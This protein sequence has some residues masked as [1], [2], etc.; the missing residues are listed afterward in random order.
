MSASVDCNLKGVTTTASHCGTQ[1]RPRDLR[2]ELRVGVRRVAVMP[3]PPKLLNLK[4]K[5]TRNFNLKL[6]LNLK[7]EFGNSALSLS[8]YSQSRPGAKPT[9]S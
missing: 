1:A 6:K 2:P 3:A 9:S 8:Y 5:L 7:S 4:F